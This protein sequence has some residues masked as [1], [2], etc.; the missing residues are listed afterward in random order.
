MKG[1][2]GVENKKLL[3]LIFF[4]TFAR[5]RHCEKAF[6]V[7]EDFFYKSNFPSISSKMLI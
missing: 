6:S 7:D 4:T 3:S 5:N 2:Y 1:F